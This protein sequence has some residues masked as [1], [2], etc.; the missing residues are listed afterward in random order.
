MYYK[1]TTIL[2][3]ISNFIFRKTNYTLR[4][5]KIQGS[6]FYDFK[7]W[8]FD[9]ENLEMVSGADQLCELYSKGNNEA[10]VEIVASKK[11]K[12]ELLDEYDEWE[13]EDLSSFDYRD[14]LFWGRTYR[15]EKREKFWICPVTLFVLGRYPNYIYIKKDNGK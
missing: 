12:S 8:G 2:S 6:W 13:G 14:R 7:N 4:F 1:I 15:N 5:V 9:Q 11:K 10:V 3:L